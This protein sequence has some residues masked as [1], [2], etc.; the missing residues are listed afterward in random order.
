MNVFKEKSFGDRLNMSAK[1]RQEQLEKVRAK[2]LAGLEGLAERQAER[3]LIAQ[4][5]EAR[6]AEREA[7]KL[8]EAERLAAEQAAAQ[9]AALEAEKQAAV[10]RDRAANEQRAKY[11]TLLAEQ[12][13]ERD[14]R[15]AARKARRR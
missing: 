8:V 7:A 10:E 11:A 15:Y 12:K 3:L 9:A 2:A 13:A 1:A 5:R 6:A 14:A 4:Q